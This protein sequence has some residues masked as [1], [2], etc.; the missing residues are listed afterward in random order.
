MD[1]K[2]KKN[3]EMDEKNRVQLMGEHGSE[4]CLHDA[5]GERVSEQHKA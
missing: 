2:N 3:P 5:L 4:S 1:E